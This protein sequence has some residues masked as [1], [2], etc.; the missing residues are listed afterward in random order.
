MSSTPPDLR[1]ADTRSTDLAS[2]MSSTGGDIEAA[3][4]PAPQDRGPDIYVPPSSSDGPGVDRRGDSSMTLATLANSSATSIASQHQQPSMRNLFEKVLP[5]IKKKKAGAAASEPE[6]VIKVWG[7]KNIDSSENKYEAY[8]GQGIDFDGSASK[9]TTKDQCASGICLN[10]KCGCDDKTDCDDNTQFC[11]KTVRGV[12]QCSD[13]ESFKAL[14][15]EAMLHTQDLETTANTQDV[16]ATPQGAGK[17]SISDECEIQIKNVQECYNT[18]H[19]NDG[20]DL[21]GL[22][23]AM[24]DKDYENS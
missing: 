15:L 4:P 18:M 22:Y 11:F 5:G 6:A 7:L 8:T 10:E 3:G 14:F 2:P 13:S 23:S 17:V 21:K 9:G 16:M 20:L 12:P 19:L 1:T 24:H